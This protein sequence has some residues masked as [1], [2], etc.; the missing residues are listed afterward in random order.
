[1][2]VHRNRAKTVAL[3][4]A[5]SVT[6]L[7]LGS[8]WGWPGL[9]V[10]ALLV[11]AVTCYVW[12]RGDAIVLR[13]MR[14]HPVGEAEQPML[15][16]LVRD[17]T[18]AARVPMPRVY[19]SPTRAANAFAIGRDPSQAAVCCTEGILALLDARELQAVLAHE[20]AHIRRADTLTS[21]ITGAVASLIM[22]PVAGDEPARASG[23]QGTGR[24]Q[25]WLLTVFARIAAAVVRVMVRPQREFAADTDAARIIGDPL[26][27]AAALRKLEMSTRRLVL[28]PEKDIMAISHVM[29]AGPLQRTGAG[30]FFAT[31]PPMADRVARLEQLAGYRR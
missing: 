15:Y 3:L 20:L 14:A 12:L 17:M 26:V 27:L 5:I 16:G 30:R 23:E 19:V 24:I 31:H 25:R 7:V 18:V 11:T 10:A 6:G 9:V 21:T 13:A 4:G 29:I 28:P 2:S 8:W 1:M 22:V